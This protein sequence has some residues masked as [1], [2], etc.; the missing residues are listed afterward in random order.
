VAVA[1]PVAQDR[2]EHLFPN[3]PDHSKMTRITLSHHK[4][5]SLRAETPGRLDSQPDLGDQ[6]GE[7]LQQSD[8]GNAED[9][10]PS[11]QGRFAVLMDHVGGGL[12]ARRDG[13]GRLAG[14]LGCRRVDGQRDLGRARRS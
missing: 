11:V 10:Q 7:R 2:H 13:Q 14:V 1:A 6:A 4:L 9:V 3:E 8:G 12:A 5:D